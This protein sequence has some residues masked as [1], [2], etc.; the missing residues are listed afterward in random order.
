[1]LEKNNNKSSLA[2]IAGNIGVS[3]ILTA[4]LIVAAFLIGVLVT[5]LKYMEGN[6]SGTA[7]AQLPQG[8]D[9]D[10]PIVEEPTGDIAKVTDE[11]HIR[12]NKEA[13]ISLVEYSD[14]EC[15]FC[16]QF[17]PTMQEI[18]K[19]YGDKVKWVYR[20][21]PL[22]FHENAQKEAEASECINELAGNDK[23]WEYIDLI[24]ERTTSN[25]TG[26]ALDNLGPLAAE[27]GVD[28]VQFQ[29]CLDSNKYEQHV[30]DEMAEGTSAGVSGTPATFIINSK[31]ES[32]LI[33]GAQP[34]GAFKTIIDQAL[35]Q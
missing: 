29:S 4:L 24:F 35:S 8:N 10:Q 23:M 11:D 15:P 18:I 16:K 19:T 28:Q 32:K 34:I 14:L 27:I 20:H 12:G 31:G 2:T 1:V 7:S 26:F 5:K 9:D 6:T 13:E 21:Y 25:G 22:D 30:K 33:S 3:Y 17:H